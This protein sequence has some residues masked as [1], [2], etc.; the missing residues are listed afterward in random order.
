MW[1]RRRRR[2]RREE[3]R[4]GD[5]ERGEEQVE[6]G[7]QKIATL[8]RRFFPLLSFLLSLSEKFSYL[9]RRESGEKLSPLCLSL[10]LSLSTRRAALARR[11]RTRRRETGSNSQG[12]RTASE[13]SVKLGSQRRVRCRRRRRLWRRR[14]IAAVVAPAPLSRRPPRRRSRWGLRD[15]E[16]DHNRCREGHSASPSGDGS[17]LWNGPTATT[18]LPLQWRPPRASGKISLSSGS[19]QQALCPREER[20]RPPPCPIPLPTC[21]RP[22]CGLS[23]IPPPS[24]SSRASTARRPRSRRRRRWPRRAAG[25][26]SPRAPAPATRPLPPPRGLPGVGSG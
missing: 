23:S 11:S 1:A 24:S 19:R 14:A 18:S 26:S 13:N 15:T 22:R 17:Q 20:G 5:R 9:S 21:P 12:E 8:R 7:Q 10:S 3:G 25:G 4:R 16:N 6:I 2:R